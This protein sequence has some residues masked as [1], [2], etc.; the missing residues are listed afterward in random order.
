MFSFFNKLD[1]TMF[2]GFATKATKSPLA[3]YNGIYNPPTSMSKRTAKRWSLMVQEKA[4]GTKFEKRNI[5]DF[6]TEKDYVLQETDHHKSLESVVVKKFGLEPSIARLKILNGEIWVKNSMHSKY[7][8]LKPNAKVSFGDTICAAV[9]K[10]PVAKVIK[11]QKDIQ[12]ENLKD[13][14]LYKDDRIIVIN[15]WNASVHGSLY[16]IQVV[17]RLIF[18]LTRF[19]PLWLEKTIQF[20]SWYIAWIKAPLDV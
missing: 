20:P 14:V 12:V 3:L 5:N 17:P 8:D 4:Q 9:K 2:R 13:S 18:L 1:N 7:M 15:K 11:E 19:Y 16:L 10:R 6:V